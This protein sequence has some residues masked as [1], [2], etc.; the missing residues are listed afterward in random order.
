MVE[1]DRQLTAGTAEKCVDLNP[2]YGSVPGSQNN[3]NTQ[4]QECP[5][6]CPFGAI[7]THTITAGIFQERLN[8][9]KIMPCALALF[10]L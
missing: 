1:A 5:R 2:G 4:P 9:C 7:R 8:M 6:T 3:A 10:I